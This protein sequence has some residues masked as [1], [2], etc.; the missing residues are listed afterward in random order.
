M[1]VL[2]G[3]IST[4]ITIGAFLLLVPAPAKASSLS[5]K[6]FLPSEIV[7]DPVANLSHTGELRPIIEAVSNAVLSVNRDLMSKHYTDIKE[8]GRTVWL[9]SIDVSQRTS[10]RISPTWK[11]TD[12]YTNAVVGGIEATVYRDA[13]MKESDPTRSFRAEFFPA[14]GALRMFNWNDKHETMF[15]EPKGKSHGGYVAYAKHLD[16]EIWRHLEWDGSGTLI[17]R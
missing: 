9:V 11:M 2:L 8:F 1:K 10:W 4:F 15:V 3:W 17:G 16:G 7:C 14:T 12:E 6:S 13:D 5:T